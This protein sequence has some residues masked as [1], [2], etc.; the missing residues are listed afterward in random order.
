MILY[1][2]RKKNG[3]KQKD[4]KGEMMKK[5]IIILFILLNLMLLPS[6]ANS[7]KYV[8]QL[9]AYT[10]EK[11]A[12]D[13]YKSLLLNDY[14]TYIS[15]SNYYYVYVGPFDNKADATDELNK[16]KIS[17][18]T[19]YIKT[20]ENDSLLTNAKINNEKAETDTLLTNAESVD[21]EYVSTTSELN[22]EFKISEIG[23]SN[24]AFINDIIFNGVFDSNII[25]FEVK[26]YWIP[27]DN[28]F[29]YFTYNNT[30]LNQNTNSSLTVYLNS[31]P[32]KSYYV[33]EKD[34]VH[35]LMLPGK[36]LKKGFNEIKFKTYSRVSNLPCEDRINPGNWIVIDKNSYIHVEYNEKIDTNS[37]SDFPYPYFKNTDFFSYNAKMIYPVNYES[38]DLSPLFTFVSNIGQLL[39]YQ[40][41]DLG[42]VDSNEIDKNDSNYIYVGLL[43]NLPENLQGYILKNDNERLKKDALIEEI[44]LNESKKNKLLIITS[45]NQKSL[46]NAITAIG[47]AEVVKQMKSSKVWIN[48]DQIFKNI[49]F[50]DNSFISLKDLGY[51]SLISEG[52]IK[53]ISNYNY[54][55]PKNWK[56]NEKSAFVLKGKI[57]GIVDKKNSAVSVFI[58]SSPIGSVSFENYEDG[59]FE[60]SFNLTEEI[61]NANVFNVKIVYDLYIDEEDCRLD[62]RDEIWSYI[63]NETG[64]YLPHSE[65]SEFSLNSLAAP[66][67]KN[68]YSNKFGLILPKKIN[69]SDFSKISNVIQIIS[70]DSKVTNKIPIYKNGDLINENVIVYGTPE[71][72]EFIKDLNNELY[73]KFDDK[74]EKYIKS[75]NIDLLDNLYN[76]ASTIQLVNSKLINNN[77]ALVLSANNDYGFENI[78]KAFTNAFFYNTADSPAILIDSYGLIHSYFVKNS[79]DEST[80]IE[81]KLNEESEKTINENKKN[82]LSEF[83]ILMIV[84]II[85]LI[86][87][88]MIIILLIINRKRYK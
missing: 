62:F 22:K 63:S 21:S 74:F 70:V 66:F 49:K 52:V 14:R 27:N 67:F 29:I 17:G 19:G 10:Y 2:L 75:K 43:K 54:S 83:K 11:N 78:E 59:N 60:I 56:L 55:V 40:K 65:K 23:V 76:D 4:F 82:I 80:L 24:E 77:Y 64:F 31:I 44:Y 30:N 51:S 8:V 50:I 72:N 84:F 85:V 9:G 79:E 32:I 87:T 53:G 6:F 41:K 69:K 15:K 28:N 12:D 25:Y 38:S 1:Y 33:N 71:N 46:D 5:N 42:F 18:Y 68:N 45:I 26:D 58:N 86:A 88:I 81:K 13:M 35:K 37:V 48:Q 20:V 61:I 39:R 7:E 34:K 16:L 36:A 3:I 47:N 73:F 57:S